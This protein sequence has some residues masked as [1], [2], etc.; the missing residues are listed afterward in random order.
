LVLIPKKKAQ[1]KNVIVMKDENE[2]GEKVR[3]N[4]GGW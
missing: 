1:R 4:L 2:E 3:K